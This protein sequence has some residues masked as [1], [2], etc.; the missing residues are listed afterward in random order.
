MPVYFIQ[1]TGPGEHI[2]IGVAASP[3]KRLADMQTS[4]PHELVLRKVIEGDKATESEMHIRFAEYH[5]RG[6]W[7]LPDGDLLAF[8][9]PPK[10]RKHCRTRSSKVE[11]LPFDLPVVDPNANPFDD[12]I[13]HILSTPEG[14]AENPHLIEK[15]GMQDDAPRG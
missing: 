1:S 7:F 4:S 2:K 15:Y 8:I 5:F 11:P 6:E 12:I 14:R 13:R 10:K 3:S 9:T